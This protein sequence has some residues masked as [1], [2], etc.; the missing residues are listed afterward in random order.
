MAINRRLKGVGIGA[1]YFAPYQYEAWSRIPEVMIS[2]IYNRTE[3]RAQPI[4][5]RYGIAR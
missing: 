3:S 1:G 4:M 2:A 5:E